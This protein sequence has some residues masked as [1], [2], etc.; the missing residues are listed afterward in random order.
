MNTIGYTRALDR[1]KFTRRKF[2]QMLG[3]IG[4]SAAVLSALDA[5]N[6]ST[7]SGMEAPPPLEGDPNGTKVIVL[8]AGPAGLTTAY[9]LMMRGYDVKVLEARGRPGGH[10][11]TIRTGAVSEEIGTPVQVARFDEGQY[12][13]SGAWRIPY[14]H[15]ATLYYPKLFQIPMEIHKNQ[16]W[17]AWAYMEGV[18]GQEAGQKMRIREV[19]ADMAGYT[20]EML[21]KA[22]D[23]R[24][25]ELEL[26]N[27]DID[28]LID[29]LISYGLLDRDD[30][31]YGPNGNRGV[32]QYPGA[33]N[34][35]EIESEPVPLA[36]LLPFAAE[37][38]P[39]LAGM[40][41]AA[42]TLDQQETMLQ[43]I[44]GMSSI[45]E[46][47]FVPALGDRIQ[48]WA[49]AL[50]IHQSPDHAWVVYRD[51]GSGEI[52]EEHGDYM[53]CTIPLSVLK[54]IPADFSPA[55][56][57]AILAGS[58]YA[59]VGKGG[60]QFKRRFWEDDDWIYG[61]ITFTNLPD[62][63]TV[64]YPD[65]S[66]LTQKGTL[67]AYYIFGGTATA[68]GDM[69]PDQRIENTLMH[70]E[71]FHPQTRDEYETGFT[72][73]WDRVRYSNG[74]WSGWSSEARQ[75]YYPT[76]LD[77]DGRVYLAGEHLSWVAAWQEG[78]IAAAWMQ[79]EKL[80][81]RVMQTQSGPA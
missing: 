52:K 65:Y 56:K 8:G 29:Y 46:N 77:P 9:E 39:R 13:D 80:H 25:L 30:L 19:N 63:G 78:A 38:M 17:N 31:T 69:A 68:V 50:E 57:E 16:N 26:S 11:H 24:M 18:A 48:F 61:G 21:A 14:I 20:A 62:I 72:V 22:L 35:Q 33:G 27:E 45:Y 76:L 5:W 55:Y 59:S 49:E 75:T 10:V 28:I 81:T 3:A 43:P 53:V 4:G 23:Q 51:K 32:V 44:G 1:T 67:Q 73:S 2:L 54:D 58:N 71:K 36:E 64:A 34:Q 40:F 7:A 70:L 15:R 79:I 12:Y 66:Y 37:A 47:G 41:R 6:L 60:L 42:P 74:G